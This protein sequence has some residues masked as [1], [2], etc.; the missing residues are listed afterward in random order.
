M[1]I[2][3]GIKLPDCCFQSEFSLYFLIF[4]PALSFFPVT[5][6]CDSLSLTISHHLTITVY[7]YSLLCFQKCVLETK[8]N[9]IFRGPSFL[10]SCLLCLISH[11]SSLPA[12]MFN[13]FM[14]NIA[15]ELLP[16]LRQSCGTLRLTAI[17]CCV[18]GL[19][20]AALQNNLLL[21]SA[22]GYYFTKCTPT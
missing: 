16:S 22:S 20:V 6:Q 10:L 8:N 12:G 18:Q 13:I 19:M 14:F 5:F 3:S 11:T 17:L 7:I 9:K 15:K 4:L 1:N 21:H 2:S